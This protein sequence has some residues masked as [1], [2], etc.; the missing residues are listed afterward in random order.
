MVSGEDPNAGV[1]LKV[2]TEKSQDGVGE[3]SGVTGKGLLAR[4]SG[5]HFTGIQGNLAFHRQTMMLCLSCSPPKN[6]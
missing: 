1:C 5:L 4:N 3:G 6:M 2:P